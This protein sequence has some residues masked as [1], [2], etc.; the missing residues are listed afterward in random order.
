MQA[1]ARPH[2]MSEVSSGLLFGVDASQWWDHPFDFCA[3]GQSRRSAP[4]PRV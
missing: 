3:Q 2:P 4:I 1:F